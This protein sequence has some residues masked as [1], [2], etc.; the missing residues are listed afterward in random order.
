MSLV[1]HDR[2]EGQRGPV[3]APSKETAVCRTHVPFEGS[4]D[5]G[6][7]ARTY[8]GETEAAAFGAMTGRGRIPWLLGRVATK[9][10]VRDHLASRDFAEVD[11]T[12]IIVSNDGNGCP[13]VE[14]RGARLATRGVRV[15]IA[16]KPNIAV[17]VA[18]RVRQ[19]TIPTGSA[20]MSVGLGIDIESVASR[21]ASFETTI[22]S[23]AERSLLDA[24]RDDRDAWLTR[25]WAVKEAAAKATGL[26]LRG[27]PKD[28][29]VD[30]LD[31]D[32]VRCCGRWIAT[33]LLDSGGDRYVVAWTDS[34]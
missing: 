31:D 19:P 9:D 27:R 34:V 11:A 1:L 3:P 29:V 23:P 17:A 10:A 32:R 4:T 6:L 13:K 22:L 8:L 12:R 18:A 30:A 15:S 16:H 24:D 20:P 26:G 5:V 7:L 33:A 21:P 25:M 28:F 2:S 14:V